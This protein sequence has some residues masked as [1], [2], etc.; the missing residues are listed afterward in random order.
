MPTKKGWDQ[1]IQELVDIIAKPNW[2]EDG[3]HTEIVRK[4]SNACFEARISARKHATQPISI[5]SI[6]YMTI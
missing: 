2:K 5:T 1:S 6:M 4:L 3:A